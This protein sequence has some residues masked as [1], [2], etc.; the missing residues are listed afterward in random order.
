MRK[1]SKLPSRVVTLGSQDP[2]SRSLYLNLERPQ[3]KELQVRQALYA[4]IDKKA[5][6]EALYYGVPTPTETF[7]P[8]QSFYYNPGLPVQEFS[9][10][11]AQQILDAAGWVPGRDRIRAKRRGASVFHQLDHV[12]R[13]ASRAGAAVSAADVCRDRRRDDHLEPSRRGDVGRILAAIAIRF[14]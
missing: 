5:I 7:M 4:A 1:L 14:G 3:F 11:R 8:R 12:R 13:P 10:K 2:H 6:I 9:V